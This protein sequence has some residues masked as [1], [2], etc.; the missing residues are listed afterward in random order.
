MNSYF[1]ILPT[2]FL[3]VS[4]QLL[5]GCVIVHQEQQESQSTLNIDVTLNQYKQSSFKQVEATFFTHQSSALVFRVL[6]DIDKTSQWL[7]RVDSLK[8]LAVYNNHQ[9][10]L[11][12]II[13]SPWPFQNRELI[14]C[15]DT[16][17][18][19]NITTIKIFSCTDRVP[20][21]DRYVR[22]SHVESRW[23]IKKITASL[24]EVN[25]K[26]WLDPAGIVPAFIFNSELIESTEVDLKKLQTLIEHASLAQYPY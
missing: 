20:L 2:C 19:E 12:T 17:F 16:L 10:L 23:T 1:K 25:Y 3:L 4:L 13:N 9:Y 8:V 21:D 18:A 14:T 7:Q 26:A 11:R 5:S 6:S 22:L 24:V 15:V